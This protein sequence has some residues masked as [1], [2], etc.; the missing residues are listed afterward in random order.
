MVIGDITIRYNRTLYA[1]F[2]VPYTE[3][4]VAMIV[5]VKEAATRNSLIFLRPLTVDLW[6][7]CFAF[8]VYT[9]IVILILE[10][11]I[12]KSLGGSISGHL[13][14]VV[15]LSFFA[16]RKYISS[17]KKLYECT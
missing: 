7:A 6:F 3:S 16:Y 17:L 5:P 14:T 10:P 8:F 12:R 2:S 4:G 15:Y 13:G 11:K 1:D 9:G